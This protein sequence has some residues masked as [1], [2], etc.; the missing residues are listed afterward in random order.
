MTQD[1]K[2]PRMRLKRTETGVGCDYSSSNKSEIR[3][4]V[5]RLVAYL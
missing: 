5:A 2:G 3:I 1:C 4:M